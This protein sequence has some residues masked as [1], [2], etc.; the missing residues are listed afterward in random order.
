M[1][2]LSDRHRLRGW[3][4]ARALLAAS[5]AHPR[6]ALAAAAAGLVNGATMVVGAAAVGWATDHLV[7]PALAGRPVDASAWWGSA[8][9]IIGVSTVRW[10]T[11]LARGVATGRVQH[12]AQ[13]DTRRAVVHRYLDLDPSWHRRHSPGQLLAHAVSDVDALWSPV[14]WLYFA[15]GMTNMLVLALA[16]LFARDRALGLVGTG[17]VTAVLTLNVLYQRLLLPR[18]RAAQQARADV[19]RVA[20]ESIEADAVVRS[21]GLDARERARFAPAV[22]ALRSANTRLARV[23]AVFDPV[24]ELLP[25]ASV[26][27]V[28]AVGAGRVADGRISVG[29]LVGVVYLLL[30]V[31]IPLSVIS[32]FLSMVPTSVA[33]GERVVSV[34]DSRESTTPGPCGLRGGG[35]VEVRA[36]G[37]SVR[38]QDRDVLADVDLVLPA[39]TVTAVVGTTGSGK[40]TLLDVLA[41]L[42]PASAG[43]VA[44]DDVDVR[45]LS[46]PARTATVAVVPQTGFLFAESVRDNLT[47]AGHPREAR[48]F[49][50][51]EIWAALH[52][53]AADEVVTGLPHG[54]DTVVGERGATLSGGQRQRIALARAV[55]RAPRLLVLDDTTSALD[56]RV[57]RTV[58]ARLAELVADGRTTVLMAANRP[59]SL[60]MADQVVLLDR[61]R[62][63]DVGT[64]HELLR[65]RDEYHRIVTAYDAPATE[66]GPNGDEFPHAS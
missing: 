26:L 57:E 12:R 50:D 6:P 3:S 51:E 29:V 36:T 10:L 52:V 17:L 34:L 44:Y 18:A 33:G 42:L 19:G 53:A 46:G 11:I 38:H 37:I 22:D 45:R 43:T 32:R 24:L 60:T 66:E 27:A 39:G 13:A 20:H 49:T 31:S 59:A 21:L 30:T 7:V 5:R 23:S 2:S 28:L 54:L 8:A 25:T 63:A 41:G 58:L 35:P 40:S 56:A 15:L 9:A 16:E 65:R 47:L 48:A 14:Q 55:L 61:G 62:V 64:H 4:G 1:T